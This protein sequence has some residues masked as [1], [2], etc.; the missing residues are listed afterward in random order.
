M[1]EA[2]PIMQQVASKTNR[3]IWECLKVGRFVAQVDSHV[4][5]GFYVRT[6]GAID[7]MHAATGHVILAHQTPEVCSGHRD[8]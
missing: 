4:S 1:T 6:G 3:A 8:A 5:S 2:L 7:L